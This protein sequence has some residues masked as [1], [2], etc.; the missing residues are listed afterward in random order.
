M[1]ENA[2][3]ENILSIS[4]REYK[5]QIDDLKGSLLGLKKGSEEYEKIAQEVRDKQAKLNEVLNDSKTI[6]TAAV[7]SMAAMKKE[8]K[9][10]KSEANQIDVGSNRFKELSQQI[11][12]T[13]EKLKEL[14]AGQGTYSRNVG[15]Y[16][17]GVASLR[18]EF[19]ELQQQMARMLA[20]GVAPTDAGFVELAKKAGNMKDAIGDAQAVISHFADDTKTLSTVVD[21][22]KTGAAAYGAY[23]GALSM[24]GIENEN[25]NKSLET[26]VA[27]TTT[28]N[29][30]Q[31]LQTA[32]VDS[33]SITYRLYHSVI[34]SL[35]L[36][37]TK[38]NAATATEATT[39]TASTATIKAHT[40][41]M[42]ADT[43]ATGAATT[44]TNIFKKALI[45]TG[46]GAIVVA[47]GTLI[48]N[49]GDLVD[50]LT[51]AGKW[52][53]KVTGLLNDNEESEKKAAD[54]AKRNAEFQ[55]ALA[56]TEKDLATKNAELTSTFEVLKAKWDDLDT[57]EEKRKFVEDYKN[58]MEALGFKID[59]VNDAE[60]FFS[61]TGAQNFAKSIEIRAKLL[62][63]QQK[64]IEKIK[65]IQ[66][67]EARD[68]LTPGYLYSEKNLL[69][70][71]IQDLS[72][73]LASLEKRY[74][75]KQQQ[76]TTQHKTSTT[77]KTSKDDEVDIS[78]NIEK[79]ERL[80][81]EQTKEIQYS[82]DLLKAKG[83]ASLDDEIALEQKK[84][85]L[86]KK[87]IEDA[88]ADREEQL[89][90]AGLTAEQM[91]Q[92]DDDLYNHRQALLETNREHQ[93]SQA[94]FIGKK[95]I[96]TYQKLKEN[97]TQIAK[98][99][100]AFDT[101]AGGAVSSWVNKIKDMEPEVAKAYVES[102]AP[103]RVQEEILSVYEAYYTENADKIM[104]YELAEEDRAYEHAQNMISISKSMLQDI[105][106]NF[107]EDSTMYLD[108]Q[109][110]V[111]KMEE[112]AAEQHYAKVAKIQN[113]HSKTTKKNNKV[114]FDSYM[115]MGSGISDLMDNVAG[116]MEEDIRN[117]QENGKISEEE[118][119]KQFET[120]K[121]LQ[122]VSATI[123]MIQGAITAY[124]TA[125]SLG[126]IA[127]PIVGG[128][129]AAAVTAMGIMNIQKIKSQQ[130]GSSGD[131][132][133]AA[134][135][136]ATRE[137]ANVDFSGVNVNPLLDETADINRMT[138]LSEQ[139]QSE[140]R[141]YI[142]QSDIADSMQQVQI[143]QS[144]TTF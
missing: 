49:L 55:E 61:T 17:S 57:V 88:I 35:G 115:Q 56:K 76:R 46:I 5:K 37:K 106:V 34:E 96:E 113:K 3:T 135:T 21:I 122:L 77:S 92:I 125:Q 23:K 72:K 108:Q 45:S 93:I 54:A 127:G 107:G 100:T 82:Y 50:G 38:L 4:L 18:S 142:L 128:I 110:I 27:I 80:L 58:E 43:A 104:E 31:T 26:M 52:I 75:S 9:E 102:M 28:L 132:S 74:T 32:L 103:K 8:L 67:S 141:V 14:E 89:K 78:G 101:V 84:Y 137:A 130:W 29:S 136:P 1:A 73:E 120:V 12:E 91:K 13:T 86:K 24:F 66:E 129:N 123:N 119:K 63:A 62:I 114:T 69:I 65:Q 10:L 143:R 71:E 36:S 98:N 118:A 44:A 40:G 11:Y 33:S 22:A 70:A 79:L 112:E 105:A 2:T 139:Q 19:K 90:K 109:A 48:T 6:S 47:I 81:D 41:A 30:L 99:V 7:N 64:L 85:E 121:T 20:D 133:G 51:A 53:G 116:I 134:S 59:N 87:F 138:T 42:V 140:Q 60:N 111:Y 97:Y 144:N 117:K 16:E 131:T 124:S 39:T 68:P 15:N 95:N 126:P 94:E 25:V 83:E